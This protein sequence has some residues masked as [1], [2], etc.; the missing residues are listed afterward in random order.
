MEERL[1][2][3]VLKLKEREG[4]SS[5]YWTEGVPNNR[6]C[7]RLGMEGIVATLCVRA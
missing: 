6:V 4:G 2:P 3:R 7:V 1:V 5:A